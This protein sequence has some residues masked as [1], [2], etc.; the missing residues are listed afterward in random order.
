[1]V[2]DVG[3]SFTDPRT[4]STFFSTDF[5]NHEFHLPKGVK[6]LSV[7]K[8]STERVRVQDSTV[9]TGNNC[10]LVQCRCVRS[11]V[12]HLLNCTLFQITSNAASDLN[13]KGD[14]KAIIRGNEGVNIMGRTVEFKMGGGIELRAVSVLR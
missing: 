6:V 10:V 5:E 14:S 13:I 11:D 9:A 8:A 7:K 12:R 4:Q 2:S 3:I 1:M